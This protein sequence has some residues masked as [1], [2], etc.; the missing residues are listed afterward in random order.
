MELYL[1]LHLV[2]MLI[3]FLTVH[4][5]K[6]IIQPISS[7]LGP[8]ST[9]LAIGNPSCIKTFQITFSN[10]FSFSISISDEIRQSETFQSLVNATILMNHF[11]TK[12]ELY[13]DTILFLDSNLNITQYKIYD[14]KSDTE[15]MVNSLSLSIRYSESSFSLVRLLKEQNLISNAKFGFIF[16]KAKDYKKGNLY[17]GGIP[18]NVIESS[19]LA[20]KCPVNT[21]VYSLK[22]GCE[23]NGFWI[24]FKSQQK[25]KYKKNFASFFQTDSEKI[26]V[27]FVVMDILKHTTFDSIVGKDCEFE[28]YQ[29]FYQRLRCRECKTILEVLPKIY[30]HFGKSSLI[31]EPETLVSE[32]N[33]SCFLQM[34]TSTLSPE[35]WVFG[36]TFLSKFISEFDYDKMMIS[37]YV[38]NFEEE[39]NEKVNKSFMIKYFIIFNSIIIVIYIGFLLYLKKYL[40]NYF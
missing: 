40:Y 5:E 7:V 21:N 2:H 9:S 25:M 18:R 32:V 1:Y 4:S 11:A 39:P 23:L 37:L 28:N 34:Q 29:A 38:N 26:I 33:N 36:T 13:I 6:I 31:L 30:L 8:I 19:T 17:L 10:E 3:L 27:P 16:N 20:V 15:N 14:L 12:A 22:W 24:E 35:Q